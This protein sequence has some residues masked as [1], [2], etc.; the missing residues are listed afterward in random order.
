MDVSGHIN[1][2]IPPCWFPYTMSRMNATISELTPS[3]SLM[4]ISRHFSGLGKGVT[5][6]DRD[7]STPLATQN[8]FCLYVSFSFMFLLD[9]KIHRRQLERE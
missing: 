1:S 8:S 5:A 2:V 9:T 6:H 4:Y 3:L 7:S